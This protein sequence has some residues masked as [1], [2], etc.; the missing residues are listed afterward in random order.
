MGQILRI[1]SANL[2][3][4]GADAEGFAELAVR[5]GADIV[6]T[7]ELSFEQAEALSAVYPY[8]ELEPRDDY[9]GMGLV[10]RHPAKVGRLS[11]PFRDGQRVEIHPGDWPQLEAAI[12]VINVHLAAPTLWPPPQGFFERVRQLP[13]LLDH[14]GSAPAT[15]R[16]VI[17]DFNSTPAWPAYWRIRRHLVDAAREVAR[18]EG[19]LPRRTWGPTPGAPR[20]LRIDHAFTQDVA[21]TRFEVHAVP[22][23]DH[24]AILVELATS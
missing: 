19:R 20:M 5:L 18:R 13:A 10:L 2:W 17:G 3:N 6:A 11:M 9:M 8:G 24:S 12:E 1:L 14:L 15:R 21:A 4:G 16:V 22:G 23:G 7:Q